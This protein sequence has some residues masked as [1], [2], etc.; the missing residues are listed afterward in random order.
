MFSSMLNDYYLENKLV[1]CK[2]K[3]EQ[4]ELRT[5]L[6]YVHKDQREPTVCLLNRGEMKMGE[7]GNFPSLTTVLALGRK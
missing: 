5:L 6:S 4:Q 3:Q 7:T 2:T 1:F